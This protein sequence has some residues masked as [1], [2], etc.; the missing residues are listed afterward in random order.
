M[1]TNTKTAKIVTTAAKELII[2]NT[3]KPYDAAW[4]MLSSANA[5]VAKPTC[6]AVKTI[7]MYA[8][9]DASQAKLSWRKLLYWLSIYCVES[10]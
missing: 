3:V 4:K 5:F 7:A 6:M 2:V 1:K 9:T 10:V 8:S